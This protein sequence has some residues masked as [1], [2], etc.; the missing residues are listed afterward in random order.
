MKKTEKFLIVSLLSMV[1]LLAGCSSGS[2][3]N[4]SPENNCLYN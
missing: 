2:G 4:D 3:S 1:C